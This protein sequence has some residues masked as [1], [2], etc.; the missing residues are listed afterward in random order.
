MELIKANSGNSSPGTW[1][2]VERRGQPRFSSFIL[3]I[4]QGSVFFLRDCFLNSI[5]SLFAKMHYE[6]YTPLMFL[7]FLRFH[8]TR[9]GADVGKA[10]ADREFKGLFDC[11]AKSYKV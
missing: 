1:R 9:L 2:R 3:W 4:L 6:K 8:R 10:A 11:I 7:N 5:R